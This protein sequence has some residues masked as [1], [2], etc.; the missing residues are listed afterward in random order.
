M[1]SQRLPPCHHGNAHSGWQ[2][3]LP[4]LFAIRH[5]VYENSATWWTSMDV[6]EGDS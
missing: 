3:A 4:L 2:H 5:L 6:V 1:L